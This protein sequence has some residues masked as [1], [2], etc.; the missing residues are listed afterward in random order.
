MKLLRKT[1]YFILVGVLLFCAI[2][3]SLYQRWDSTDFSSTNPANEIGFIQNS[4]N[5][6]RLKNKSEISWRSGKAESKV[7][8]FDT[9]YTGE[10]STSNVILKSGF[11][12]QTDPKSLVYLDE[13]LDALV[14]E[15]SY[16]SLSMTARAR[17]S[18]VIVMGRNEYKLLPENAKFRLGPGADGKPEIQVT[19]GS[20]KVFAP[21]KDEPRLITA[22]QSYQLDRF[23]QSPWSSPSQL[24]FPA[25]GATIAISPSMTFTWQSSCEACTS[26]VEVYSDSNLTQNIA[27]ATSRE[28]SAAIQLPD[29]DGVYFWRVR[30]IDPTGE[31]F[32]S[33]VVRF[34]G[35]KLETLQITEPQP[36][37]VYRDFM[38]TESD[39]PS[40]IQIRWNS[41]PHYDYYQLQI[42]SN[43]D[44]SRIM[45]DQAS[46]SPEFTTE[47]LPKGH[48]Y[49]RV[50]GVMK[51]TQLTGPWNAGVHFQKRYHFP[52]VA[53]P[54]LLTLDSSFWT[55]D[56][57]V[58]RWNLVPEAN[59]YYVEIA[60]DPQFQNIIAN[61]TTAEPSWTWNN[62]KAG[63]FFVRVSSLNLGDNRG[64]FSE[65]TNLA[66][67]APAPEKVKQS[68]ETILAQ[69]KNDAEEEPAP[70]KPTSEPGNWYASMGLGYTSSNTDFTVLQ[71]PSLLA[72]FGVDKTHWSFAIA[73]QSIK[74]KEKVGGDP[75]EWKTLKVDYSYAIDPD[76]VSGS[77]LYLKVNVQDHTFPILTPATPSATDVNTYKILAVGLGLKLEKKYEDWILSAQGTYQIPI[78]V[79]SQVQDFKLSK[80]TYFDA[81]IKAMKALSERLFIGAALNSRLFQHE[82]EFFDTVNSV[83]DS[84]AQQMMFND[85][86][87]Q[88]RWNF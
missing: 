49:T 33:Q 76:S 4:R 39:L 25:D 7:H 85:L 77:V 41:A 30:Q 65:M 18:I 75:M 5:D 20:L 73:Y 69:N 44:F 34:T 28:N 23:H 22:N 68:L 67:N 45:L 72:E 43:S 29:S 63:R 3:L 21:G 81:E 83:T 78:S 36:E 74:G 57:P 52:E 17:K 16:G 86:S 15:L 12:M 19:A 71:A 6:V 56:P 61:G 27:K 9:I 47:A 42:A 59:G 13:N 70:Q 58:L 48:Y 84:G 24:T 32:T 88:M 2:S 1:D 40:T 62:A 53:P 64:P 60:S 8:R 46:L 26:Q 79:S 55:T 14:L 37:Q 35:L 38:K 31:I 54:T 50:R 87:F 66:V 80:Q 51:E 82:Y 11:E 10:N